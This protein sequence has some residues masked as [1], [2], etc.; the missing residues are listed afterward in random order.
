MIKIKQSGVAL[1]TVM[2]IL[3]LATITAVSM[4]SKQNIDI[5]RSANILNFDQGIEVTVLMESYAK[6]ALADH[7]LNNTSIT[8]FQ[9]DFSNK[10]ASAGVTIDEISGWGNGEVKD[11]QACF[12]LN[13]LVASSGGTPVTSGNTIVTLQQTRLT[14][15]IQNLNDDNSLD[16]NLN[17]NFVDALIDWIDNNQTVL[18]N[19]A[20]DAVYSSL[21]KNPYT[22]ANQ[23]L[24]DISELLLVQG[25][26]HQ[27]YNILKNY[28]CVLD[29]P[30]AALN[31][32]TAKPHVLRSL[33]PAM[34]PQNA[35]SLAGSARTTNSKKGFA[36]VADFIADPANRGLTIDPSGLDVTSDHFELRTEVRRND[37]V[38]LYTSRILRTTTSS[39]S[40]F[41]VIKRSRRLL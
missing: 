13:S 40:R 2:L 30:S 16:F 19:G 21:E 11:T 36:S 20:E 15:L 41:D 5:H 22:T 9:L 27:S 6:R 4:V 12:N 1:I 23:Y 25:M 35:A 34:T 37:T 3:S 38:L 10:L 29:D 39:T 14:T 31:V 8:S 24:S 18:G 7:F 17:V 33:D 28:V 32:N 26:E